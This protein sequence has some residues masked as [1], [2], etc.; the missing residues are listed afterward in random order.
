MPS[1][2]RSCIQR[3]ATRAYLGGV[4]AACNAPSLPRPV[5]G[6]PTSRL[7]HRFRCREDETPK[8]FSKT[9]V[10]TQFV[11]HMDLFSFA[12]KRGNRGFISAKTGLTS[13]GDSNEA[14]A[15]FRMYGMAVDFRKRPAAEAIAIQLALQGY[16]A[17]RSP[18]TCS[19]PQ[20]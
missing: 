15:S 16:V 2:C 19:G 9:Y 3:L 6:L 10:A 4:V 20:W 13:G 7:S 1:S 17:N 8:L 14:M 12:L 11:A 5:V 18:L